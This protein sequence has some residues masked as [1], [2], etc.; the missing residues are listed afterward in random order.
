MA[1]RT[2][3]EL[4]AAF[5]DFFAERGHQVAETF[6]ERGYQPE[7]EVQK[8]AAADLVILQTPVN[9]F[10][11]ARPSPTTPPIPRSCG[12]CSASSRSAPSTSPGISP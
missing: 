1:P 9:W 5:L 3:D 10:G 7:E 8:H 2:A 6:V 11:A 4:R 12:T